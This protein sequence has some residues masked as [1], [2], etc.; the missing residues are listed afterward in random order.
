MAIL[1][2]Y[3]IPRLLLILKDK[4]ALVS[5]VCIRGRKNH[6]LTMLRILTPMSPLILKL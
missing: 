4:L 3:L 6:A 5:L 2:N 1:Q